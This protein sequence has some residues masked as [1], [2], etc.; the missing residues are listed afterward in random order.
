MAYFY[1]IIFICLGFLLC[2]GSAF[3]SV[4]ATAGGME[5]Q[6]NGAGW[7]SSRLTA[8]N[9]ALAATGSTY[10]SPAYEDSSCLF[11]SPT[12]VVGIF[13]AFETR[14]VA[15]SCPSN[16][17]LVNSACICN[18]PFVEDSTHTSCV[19][20]PSP[21]ED[22]CKNASA[23]ANSTLGVPYQDVNIKGAV[24]SGTSICVPTPGTSNPS[25]VGCTVNFTRGISTTDSAGNYTSTGTIDTQGGY[26]TLPCSLTTTDPAKPPKAEPTKCP[27]G[28]QMGQINGVDSCQPY[29]TGTTT[30]TNKTGSNSTTD[31]TGTTVNQ[32]DST[33]VC[34]GGKCTTTETTTAT[35]TPSGS[36]TSTSSSSSTVK[37]E[38]KGEFCTT[39][40]TSKEC[41]STGSGGTEDGKCRPG[42]TSAGCAELGSIP[43]ATP[44]NNVNKA[45]TIT[46]DTGW[47]AS[48]A[49]CPAPQVLNLALV[50]TVNVPWDLFCQFA[51]G[52][53]PIVLG[54]SY[55]TAAFTF[56]GIG[57]KS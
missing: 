49:A 6:A 18:A 12:G 24:S 15:A 13:S 57:R 5:Y 35:N 47:G 38:S 48:N 7:F 33:T 56:F 50:G 19:A 27:S 34:V 55:L 41:D 45:M 28:Q 31:S 32:K 21:D 4:P 46:K 9:T 54:L 42:D 36:S 37:T 3:A 39:N 16:S 51:E 22:A 11:T 30:T 44:V 53:R 52:I 10:Y 1:R 26:P 23:V 29:G 43:E 14:T 25:S 20:P 2:A 17:S 40:P 8:C